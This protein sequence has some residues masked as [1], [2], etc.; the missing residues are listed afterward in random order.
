MHGARTQALVLRGVGG[1]VEFDL[2]TFGLHRPGAEG[3]EL[4]EPAREHRVDHEVVVAVVGADGIEPQPSALGIFVETRPTP[5][6][7]GIQRRTRG[8][9]IAS[10]PQVE[11]ARTVAVVTDPQCAALAGKALP[12]AAQ[13]PELAAHEHAHARGAGIGGQR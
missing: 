12:V 8:R 4:R 10:Q 5:V 3:T 13:L 1:S 7:G 2:K 9:G 11:Q 6:V